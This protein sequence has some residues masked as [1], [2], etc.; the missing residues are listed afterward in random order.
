[1][2]FF[3]SLSNWKSSLNEKKI[4]QAQSLGNCPDCNGK[5]FQIPV[6]NEYFYPESL[7]CPS[8]NGSG[9]FSQWSENQQNYS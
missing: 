9:S 6:I 4:A 1:M 7:D 2:G 5:G 8:C 3:Q